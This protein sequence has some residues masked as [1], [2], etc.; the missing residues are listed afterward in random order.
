MCGVIGV[1]SKIQ[2][3]SLLVY[4]G[5][6]H[7]QHRGQ[8]SAGISTQSKVIKKHGLVKNVFNED[9]IN[10]L[11]SNVSIGHVRYGTNSNY[12]ANTI[13]PIHKDGIYLVH[14]GNI[15]NTQ[16][17]TNI[18]GNS[19][20]SDS[21]YILD[22]FHFKLSEYKQISYSVIFEIVSFIMKTLKGSYSVLLLIDGF[23]MICFRDVYGI[24]P[25]IYGKKGSDYIICSESSVI[26]LLE[27]QIAR[28]VKPGE[29]IVFEQNQMPRFHNCDI[30]HGIYPCLFEY[31]YFSRI[32][33]VID[34]I[35]VYDARY[36]MGQL[37]GNKVKNL[38]INDIDT[39]VYVPESSV[40]FALGVQ[41]SLQL[42]IQCGFV[43]NNYIERT[44]IMKN[45]KLINKNIKRK[46]NGVYNVL[47]GKNI[48]IIDDSIV[49]GNTCSHIVYLAKK[50]GAKKIYFGSGAPPVLYDNRY[51]IYIPNQN[52]LIAYNRTYD[53]IADVIGV[54]KVIYNDLSEVVNTLKQMNP[55]LNG[56][57]TSMFNNIHLYE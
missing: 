16:D 20:T 44:F 57:E 5:L 4:E 51:G 6:A 53:D 11:V 43:K 29:A 39:I 2:N 18:T 25:L 49:R 35:S 54:N 28:D 10:E 22:L 21:T 17:I 26:D 42:P 31:I 47:N 45:D 14:N 13:Q 50:N 41:K 34:N 27:F 9:E 52:E 37:L 15:I 33:S 56:F 48:L 24:R 23:G 55:M 30:R 36:K 19:F 32:D 38:Q 1:T 8:D 7:L 3:A 46:V 12:D 40:I